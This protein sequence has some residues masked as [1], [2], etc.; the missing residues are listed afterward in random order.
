MF[1]Q[2]IFIDGRMVALLVGCEFQNSLDYA[3]PETKFRA[4]VINRSSW[5]SS[6]RE[7]SICRAITRRI[8]AN[9][10]ELFIHN[11]FIKTRMHETLVNKS[12][13]VTSLSKVANAKIY[14]H[15]SSTNATRAVKKLV[16]FRSN[17]YSTFSE[18][19]SLSSPWCINFVKAF[20]WI[21]K[22]KDG[23]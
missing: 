14:W 7:N 13:C 6:R 2:Q 1:I 3:R 22:F 9:C 4:E 8:L 20:S 19:Y 12:N 5:N 23:V 16:E 17:K 21:V 10:S 18:K 11:E 15:D